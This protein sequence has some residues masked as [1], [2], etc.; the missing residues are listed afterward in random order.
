MSI[1]AAFAQ[2][3]SEEVMITNGNIELPGTLSY[4][5][6]NSPLVIWVHGSGN[7]DRNGNQAGAMINANY[8]QQFRE[9]INKNDIAFL[10]YDKRTANAKNLKYI[11]K[12]GVVFK[13]LINDVDEVIN[14]FSSDERFTQIILIGHSQGSVIAMSILDNVDKYIS[15]AGPSESVDKVITKQITNQSK[16]LGKITEAHFKELKETGKIK[17]VNPF[18]M[19]IFAPVNQSFIKSWMAYN[20]SEI[21]AD[22]EIPTL[23]INGDKDLQVPIDDAKTLH[24]AL[25]SS[26][27]VIIKNMNHVL[28]EVEND[29]DNRNSY[30]SADFPISKELI[31]VISEFINK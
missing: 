9:E 26:E 25:K 14:Y 19:S 1:S 4:T 11:K 12:E 16:D 31:Q 23:I 8:I 27:L 18:L 21:I 30:I 10:S 29:A 13:D 15:L 7:I 3:K 17:E 24:E 6:E 28:K 22:V 20:P 2:V 5:Q